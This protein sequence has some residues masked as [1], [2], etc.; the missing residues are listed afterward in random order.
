[1]VDMSTP[2]K[3]LRRPVS[4][5]PLLDIPALAL[6]LGTSVRFVRRLVDE[7]RIP[8]LKIGRLVRFDPAE[9]EAWVAGTRVQP[10]PPWNRRAPIRLG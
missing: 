7:R 9:V 8:Y 3:D 4:P 6:R 1:M 2:V 5:A 10:S